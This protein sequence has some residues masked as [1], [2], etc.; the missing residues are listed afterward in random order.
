NLYKTLTFILTFMTCFLFYNNVNASSIVCNYKATLYDNKMHS[1]KVEL[2]LNYDFNIPSLKVVKAPGNEGVFN[3]SE[4]VFKDLEKSIVV[5]DI[6]DDKGKLLP[7]V[8]ISYSMDTKTMNWMFKKTSSFD[9]SVHPS[10]M[11]VQEIKKVQDDKEKENISAGGEPIDNK[12]HKCIYNKETSDEYLLWWSDNKVQSDLTGIKS[13]KA[14]KEIIEKDFKS[15]MFEGTL[16]PESSFEYSDIGVSGLQKM[17]ISV[18]K[19]FD[20]DSSISGSINASDGSVTNREDMEQFITGTNEILSPELIKILNEIFLG[21]KI[22]API[23][24]I[25]LSMMDFAKAIAAEDKD[26]LKKAYKNLAIRFAVVLFIFMLP[27]LINL[28]TNIMGWDDLPIG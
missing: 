20:H 27:A 9:S 5:K 23:I 2:E 16:C 12:A 10:L 4:N 19:K 28:V 6:I 26:A 13:S 18:A 15:S 17:S 22:V 21:I 24:V 11:K 7:C 1:T 8:S 14:T 25:V 3:V